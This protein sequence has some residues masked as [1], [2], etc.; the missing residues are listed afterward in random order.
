MQWAPWGGMRGWWEQ[1]ALRSST[2]EREVQEN[3]GIG[4]AMEK[5]QKNLL[6]MTKNQ[7]KSQTKKFR[8]SRKR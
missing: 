2:H 1:K 7:L 4:R 8:M 3:L 5:A 6:E